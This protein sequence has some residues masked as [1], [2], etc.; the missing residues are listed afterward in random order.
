MP[1][2]KSIDRIG[3]RP[4]SR[5]QGWLARRL[6]EKFLLD[7]KGCT[8]LEIGTGVGRIA[9]QIVRRGHSYV[10]VEPTASLREEAKTRLSTRGLIGEIIDDALPELS[11]LQ[12]RTFTHALALHVL[13]HAENSNSAAAWLSS[14]AARIRPGGQILIVC[15]NFL[16]LRGHFFDVDWTHQWVSTTSRIAMLGEE[17]DLKVIRETDLRGTI[18][19]PIA[20][21]PL[22]V[23][24]RLI[25][26]EFLNW[27]FR[28]FFGLRNFGSGIQSAIFWRMSWVVFQKR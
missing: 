14:I 17:L 4:G 12:D 25:P 20:K 9:E 5:L 13:E 8:V 22:G 16:D 26:T 11:R 7:A 15:P 3:N 6:V 2:E 18:Q 24:S 19:N 21:L 10:G 27:V 23:I 28:R 1:Y